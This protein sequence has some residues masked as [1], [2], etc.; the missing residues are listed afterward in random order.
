MRSMPL[1]SK[2]NRDLVNVKLASCRHRKDDLRMHIVFGLARE[3]RIAIA[4]AMSVPRYPASGCRR[5][6]DGFQL[7]APEHTS[8]SGLSSYATV[9]GR[10]RKQVKGLKM[11]RTRSGHCETEPGKQME[12]VNWAKQHVDCSL[13]GD[14]AYQVGPAFSEGAVAQ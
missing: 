2:L 11:G 7:H 9:S 8:P 14:F 4:Y 5:E 12:S 3:H 6:L 10:S 1:K 13:S